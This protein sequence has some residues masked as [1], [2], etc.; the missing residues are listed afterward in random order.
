MNKRIS[1]NLAVLG[2]AVTAA[3]LEPYVSTPLQYVYAY[4][5]AVVAGWFLGVSPVMTDQHEV[6][7]SMVNQ[8]INVTSKCS[9]FG[10]SCLLAAILVINI[11]KFKHKTKRIVALC[12]V[13]PSAYT[14]TIVVNGCR[15]VCGYYAYQLGQMML[16]VNFQ[17]TIHLGVGI[18]IF[19]STLI[20]IT[21][22]FERIHDAERI[23]P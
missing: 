8:W 9:A 22:I 13:L 10:F 16:P 17:P 18:T 7:M 14:V 19:L 12:L 23:S 6:L 4:P 15:I 11:L 20:G 2:L 5:S 3:S 21:L 1:I